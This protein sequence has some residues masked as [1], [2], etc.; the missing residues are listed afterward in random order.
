MLAQ[1]VYVSLRAP[2]CT[3]DEIQKIL[4]SCKKNNKEKDVTGVLLYSDTHFLQYLEGDY[5]NIAS[6]YDTIKLDK[7]HKHA[8]MVSNAPISKRSFPGWQMGAKKFDKQDI[9]FQSEMSASERIAFK[10]LLSGES[11]DGQL[12][13]HLVLKFFK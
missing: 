10:S 9:V 7:R 5:K 13:L 2:I 12:A 4:A 8:L 6:L 3:E 11:E 1:L